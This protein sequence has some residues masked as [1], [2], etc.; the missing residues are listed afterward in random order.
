MTSKEITDIVRKRGYYNGDII[1]RRLYALGEN[2]K[3]YEDRPKEN[4]D[5]RIPV[6][7]ARRAVMLVKGYM[8]KPGNI[9]FSGDEYEAI[10]EILNDNDSDLVTSE[11]LE[12]TLVHGVTYE[13]H[14][15][16][17]GFPMFALCPQEQ[18]IP[19]W[20]NDLKPKLKGFINHYKDYE[21]DEEKAV[22]YG[23]KEVVYYSRKTNQDDFQEIDR[24]PH[25][26]GRVPV[27]YYFMDSNKRNLFDHALPLIDGLDKI[28]SEDFANELER[29]A[30]SILATTMNFDDTPDETTGETDLDK[31]KRSKV[32]QNMSGKIADSIQYVTKPQ[33][34]NFVN[35]AAD[36]FERLIYETLMMFNPNDEDFNTASGVAAA[37]KMLPFEYL[38]SSIEAYFTQG[39]YRR[40]E[41]IYA[42]LAQSYDKNINIMFDRNLPKNMLEIS[43]IASMLQGILSDETILKIF[44]GSLVPDVPEELARKE[45]S[46]VNRLFP[47]NEQ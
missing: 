16:E 44:P 14:W 40:F 12:N 11:E 43:Q 4:P 18:A 15:L 20:T 1:K 46:A 32:I 25:G 33:V 23:E 6:P 36:R 37:Y 41:L 9:K 28:I 17:D 45:E 3:I 22:Y 47:A 5:N 19:I 26:Y 39:L 42:G 35:T 2:K 31:I 34:D 27:N 21:E 30:N 38:C 24:M 10:A 7:L 8:A 29:F 13:I